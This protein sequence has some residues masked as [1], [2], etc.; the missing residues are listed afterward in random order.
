MMQRHPRFA[1]QRQA[2]LA[3][4]IDAFVGFQIDQPGRRSLQPEIS[5]G[6]IGIRRKGCERRQRQGLGVANFGL[7]EALLLDGEVARGERCLT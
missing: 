4:I 2:R 6:Q 5:G 1:T 7:I 3:G